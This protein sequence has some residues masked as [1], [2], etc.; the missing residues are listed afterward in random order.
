MQGLLINT[1]LREYNTFWSN[2]T[3][4]QLV[5][6]TDFDGWHDSW[7]RVDGPR[8]AQRWYLF[9]VSIHVKST[10]PRCVCDRASG[11]RLQREDLDLQP[12][13]SYQ[14]LAHDVWWRK[15][16][17]VDQ[18]SRLSPYHNGGDWHPNAAWNSLPKD[19]T[20]MRAVIQVMG[21]AQVEWFCIAPHVAKV[22][23]DL[24][25]R[26]QFQKRVR[27]WV[28]FCRLA[29][30]C[31]ICRVGDPCYAGFCR[32]SHGKVI[33]QRKILRRLPPRASR[34]ALLFRQALG[35]PRPVIWHLSNCCM[36]FSIAWRWH[37]NDSENLRPVPY[38]A[39]HSQ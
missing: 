11:S 13:T 23:Q 30:Q 1:D 26:N 33:A 17:T 7:K 32:C 37:C 29:H 24:M 15:I 14:F 21:H 4:Y 36:W 9:L 18:W 2:H 38:T 20:M 25:D 10:W 31:C 34:K 22:L 8:G 19:A 35:K 5:I 12:R 6:W 39:N 3:S 27:W 16:T 28:Y